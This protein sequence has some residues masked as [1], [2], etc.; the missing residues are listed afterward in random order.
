[1]QN[2]AKPYKIYL[3]RPEFSWILAVCMSTTSMAIFSNPLFASYS[4][5]ARTTSIVPWTHHGHDTEHIHSHFCTQTHSNTVLLTHF[6]YLFT[7]LHSVVAPRWYRVPQ[8]FSNKD[9]LALV[10]IGLELGWRRKIAP[11]MY[12]C[13]S[14]TENNIKRHK[15]HR[16]AAVL[17]PCVS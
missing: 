2:Y 17:L 16:D 9:G 13:P 15:R 5:H 1:M 6:T 11:L 12:I 10:L 8:Y 14:R 3:A 7:Y 4:V